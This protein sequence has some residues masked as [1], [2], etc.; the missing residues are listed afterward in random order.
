MTARDE[1]TEKKLLSTDCTKYVREEKRIFVLRGVLDDRDT[2]TEMRH[3]R[4]QTLLELEVCDRNAR[5]GFR[6]QRRQIPPI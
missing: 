2:Q 6:L 5:C 1:Y 3:Y 4:A